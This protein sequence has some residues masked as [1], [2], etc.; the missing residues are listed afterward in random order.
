M[1]IPLLIKYLKNA[2]TFV[3]HMS[4]G[5]THL[6]GKVQEYQNCK[7][8]FTPI[9]Y[10]YFKISGTERLDIFNTQNVNFIFSTKAVISPIMF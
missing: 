8:R 10:L 4:Q 2:D 7:I 9:L 3:F 1:H 6:A 5:H